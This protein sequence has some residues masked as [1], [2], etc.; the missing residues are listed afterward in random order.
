MTALK[1]R[2]MT[3]LRAI[4]AT[5]G[6]TLHEIQDKTGLGKLSDAVHILKSG[7][8]IKVAG[9]S[10]EKKPMNLYVVTQKGSDSLNPEKPALSA[11]IPARCEFKEPTVSITGKTKITI[12]KCPAYEVYKPEEYWTRNY[13]PRYIGGIGI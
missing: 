4:A 10:K 2:S 7:G 8:Y 12:A 9:L 3:I 6:I 11:K 13:V 1:S 5:K